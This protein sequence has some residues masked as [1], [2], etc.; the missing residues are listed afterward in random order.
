VS[1]DLLRF[2]E[3]YQILQILLLKIVN[4]IS[5][6]DFVISF[7]IPKEAYEISEVLANFKAIG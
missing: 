5:L 4:F 2:T 1:F 7:V 6:R 3:I